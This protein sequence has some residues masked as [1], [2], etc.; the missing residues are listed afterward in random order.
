VREEERREDDR[1]VDPAT[2]QKRV[3]SSSS[4]RYSNRTPSGIS[5]DRLLL[6]AVSFL[7]VP[8]KFGGTTKRGIDC[9]AFTASIYSTSLQRSIPRSTDD[10]YRVGT[11]VPKDSLQF[12]DLV[13]FNTTGRTPSHV[14]LY[15]EDDLFVHASV[16]FGVTI[17]SLE[18]TYY[19]RRFV[20][21]RRLVE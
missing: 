21:A 14:G 4:T 15:I 8:Y 7:G 18:S 16:T 12:G 9:S 20:G 1:K 5:R 17:S 11:P 6:D 3:S 2:L 13:F 10:Q 19:K